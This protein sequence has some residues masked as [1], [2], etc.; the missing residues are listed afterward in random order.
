MA[1][2]ELLR[3]VRGGNPPH[4]LRLHCHPLTGRPQRAEPPCYNE[5]AEQLA[6]QAALLEQR[7]LALAPLTDHALLL[8]RAAPEANGSH[9]AAIDAALA[10]AKQRCEALWSQL[11]QVRT[12]VVRPRSAQTATGP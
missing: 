8:T 1:S 3:A 7:A 2:S 6:S 5:Q 12:G 9:D 11:S 10:Q 4:W